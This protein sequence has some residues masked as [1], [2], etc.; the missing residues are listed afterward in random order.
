M[1][2]EFATCAVVL[3]A[4]RDSEPH[5]SFVA[6][7]SDGAIAAVSLACRTRRSDKLPILDEAALSQKIVEISRLMDEM[8][9]NVL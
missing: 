1:F 3:E 2:E 9:S 7:A 6:R 8:Q 4:V 5:V